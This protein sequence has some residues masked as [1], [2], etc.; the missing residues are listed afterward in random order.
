MK[1]P[2]K[3][4]AEELRLIEIDRRKRA[5]LTDARAISRDFITLARI[6]AQMRA[7]LA[8]RKIA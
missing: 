2:P 1:Q 8:E 5:L 6:R 4:T 3:Y 7:K